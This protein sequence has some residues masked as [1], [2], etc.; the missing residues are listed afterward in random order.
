MY[1]VGQQEEL[2][3]TDDSFAL[4]DFASSLRFMECIGSFLRRFRRILKYSGSVKLSEYLI[5][6]VETGRAWN[7]LTEEIQILV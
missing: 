1:S 2:L 3:S 4:N 6:L 5:E 7:I